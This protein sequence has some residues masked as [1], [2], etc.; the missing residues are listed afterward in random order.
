[1]TTAITLWRPQVNNVYCMDAC[2]LLMALPGGSADAIITDLPYGTTA[3][4]WDTI[5]PF[6]RLWEAVQHALKPSGVFVTTASQPFTSALI[7]SNPAWFR[8]EWIWDKRS[9]TGHLNAKNRPMQQHENIIVFS[10]GAEIYNPQLR[11]GV[12]KPFGALKPS[13]SPIY[14]EH[15]NAR[16]SGIGYPLSILVFPKPNNLSGGRLHPTQK[17]VELYEYLVR[18]YTSPN[19]LVVD[20]CM[21]SATTLV[22]A[23][24]SNRNYIGG[25]KS[26]EWVRVAEMR[27]QGRGSEVR[28]SRAGQPSTL[29]LPMVDE[30]T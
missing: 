8:Y 14:G 13:F 25:D 16:G 26:A 10:A 4:S 19:D 12:A 9:P 30:I 20:P 22:A 23:R 17:P 11:V 2:D 6:D 18:T 3:C 5:I 29:R 1:M 15:K 21:G 7:M 24:A 28:A 27:L